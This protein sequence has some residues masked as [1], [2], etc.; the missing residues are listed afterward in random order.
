MHSVTRLGAVVL[1]A[2]VVAGCQ[3]RT[4]PPHSQPSPFQ[5]TTADFAAIARVLDTRAHDILTGDRAGFMATVDPADKRLMAGQRVFFA[6]LEALPVKSMSYHL[7]HYGLTAFGVGDG[8]PALAPPVTEHVE[9]R[10]PDIR[11]VA[12][13]VDETFVRRAGHWLLGAE[14]LAPASSRFDQPQSRPWFGGPIAVARKG[15]L[16]VV[17][18]RRKGGQATSLL[19]DVAADIRFDA[20]VT[21]QRPDYRL[22]VDATSNGSVTL[23]NSLG[24]EQAAADTFEVAAATPDGSRY[25]ALAG[26][27]VKVNPKHVV[28]YLR[29]PSLLKHELTHFLLRRFS[30]RQPTWLTE[31][32]ADFVGY[33]PHPESDL[34]VPPSTYRSLMRQAGSPS[35]PTS[36]VFDIRPTADYAIAHAAVLWLVDTYGMPRLIALMRAYSRYDDQQFGDNHTNHVL[37]QVDGIAEQQLAVHTFDVLRLLR[38]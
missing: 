22:L 29:D 12:N 30:P 11:P 31:G 10:G 28:E 27:R 36:G 2:A 6:N 25:T 16:V 26:E 9:L 38:S 24:S 19:H 1:T 32:V 37:E 35:L 13:A 7:E 3:A 34:W 14:R 33:Y 17:A 4:P 20:Q 15:P 5:P 23:M 18:D 21:G 8:V